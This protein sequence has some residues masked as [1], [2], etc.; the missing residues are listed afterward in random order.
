[1]A[2][3]V[4]DTF[5]GPNGQFDEHVG[6]VGAV[7]TPHPI[8]PP[9]DVGLIQSN[10]YRP[11]T[12]SGCMVASGTPAGAEY[13]VQVDLV[14]LTEGNPGAGIYGRLAMDEFSGYAAIYD[15]TAN[16]YLLVLWE[17]GTPTVLDSAS[18]GAWAA[19][20]RVMRLEI[21]NSVKRVLVDDV[22]VCSSADNTIEA[23]GRVGFECMNPA[24]S[25]SGTHLDNFI[26]SDFTG[27]GG[28]PVESEPVTF[29]EHETA[30][31]NAR[32]LVY[33]SLTAIQD[34]AESAAASV[35]V[36]VSLSAVEDEVA[37]ATAATWSITGI[38]TLNGNPV[39][40][41]TVRLINQDENSYVGTTSTA[42]DGTYAFRGVK[43]GVNY[44]ATVEFESG[45]QKYNAR[46]QPFLQATQD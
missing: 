42:A 10:R 22:A 23:P 29:Q 37:A 33:G 8:R 34:E 3:F 19:E 14:L 30:S 18:A 17:D 27:G 45:G 28:T 41:A 7:W 24:G 36:Q 35:R 40:G 32:V 9:N 20:T 43:Q 12:T 31:V 46:S 44:H 16:M 21:R 4:V 39:E 38:V 15:G 13:D 2:D 5:T 26:A 11:R 25:A 1:M 6:E